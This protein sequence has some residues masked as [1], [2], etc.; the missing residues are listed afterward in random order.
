M[1]KLTKDEDLILKSLYY[2]GAAPLDTFLQVFLNGLFIKDL[3]SFLKVQK[4]R[5]DKIVVIN[6]NGKRIIERSN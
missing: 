6:E 3:V 1:E 4:L 2:D 5:V